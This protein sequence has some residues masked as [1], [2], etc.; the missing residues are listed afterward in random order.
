MQHYRRSTSSWLI[1]QALCFCLL[2]QGSGIAQALPLPP[3]QSFVSE[4]EF[5][6]ARLATI[7]DSAESTEDRSWPRLLEGVQDSF[8]EAGNALAHWLRDTW[9]QST[10]D[11]APLRVAQAGGVLPLPPRLMAAF[12][13]SSSRS[14]GG[15]PSPPDLGSGS[16]EAT[17][18]A[19]LASL[20]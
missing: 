4:S 11:E 20:L 7:P 6:A 9:T 12:L 5:E 10:E 17:P 1:S 8:E 3:K 14:Q 13:A 2:L 15:P 16:V 19:E 18:P